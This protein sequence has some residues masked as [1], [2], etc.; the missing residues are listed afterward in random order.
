MIIAS[1]QS[2]WVKE[3]ATRE[4]TIDVYLPVRQETGVWACRIILDF[5]KR[6]DNPV[7]GENSYQSLKLAVRFARI[8]VDSFI[9]RG[10]KIAKQF[11]DGNGDEFSKEEMEKY[12]NALF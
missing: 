12:I 6:Y 2:E 9:A 5:E 1:H 11:D 8:L 4:L 7:Y 3:Q 10:W